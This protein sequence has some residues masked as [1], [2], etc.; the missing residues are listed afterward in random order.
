MGLGSA[1]AGGNPQ[2][3][4]QPRDYYGTPREVTVALLKEEALPRN[5][6]EPACG[7]GAM[8]SVIEEIAG[9]PCVVACD[10]EP[11]GYG[12]KKD[13]FDIEVDGSNF[14]NWGIITNPPFNLAVKFIEHGLALKPDMLAL[15]LK[16]TFWHAK[17]RREL[18][19]RTK[20]A[21]IYPLT[22]RPDF[23]NKG[24]PTMDICWTVWRRDHVG[25]TI[26]KPLVKP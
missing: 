12:I 24:A 13:F 3:G 14:E 23:L 20:P 19:E 15:V 7:D 16:A 10:I 6:L 4:R 11:L 22:W 25:A 1:M 5:V 8:A 26:Y 9:R 2:D 17:S 21:A 18:F